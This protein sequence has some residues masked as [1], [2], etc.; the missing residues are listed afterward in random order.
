MRILT[1]VAVFNQTPDGRYHATKFSRKLSEPSARDWVKL[2]W[3]MAGP[4]GGILDSLKMNSY[5]ASSD[6]LKAGV[7]LAFGG[8]LFE[9]LQKDE[10]AGRFFHVGMAAQDDLPK[11]QYPDTTFPYA[12]F[13]AGLD[14]EE[15]VFVDVGGGNGHVIR[16]IQS[17]NPGIKARFVLV[18]LPHTVADAQKTQPPFECV[19]GDFFEGIPVKGAK[20]YHIRRCLH[21]WGDERCEAILR[22]IREAMT[23]GYSRLLIHEFA[24]PKIAGRESRSQMFDIVMMSLSGQERDEEEWLRLLER[25]GL[26][27]VKLWRAGVG[28]MAIIEASAD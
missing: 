20:V 13:M 16:K 25:S 5:R 18:D 11:E 8:S 15:A 4:I 19:V 3:Y 12:E 9:A 10:E 21:D 27:F 1:S 23:P 14:G 28:D 24:L 2:G 17:D 22:S 6:P 7:G 26:K